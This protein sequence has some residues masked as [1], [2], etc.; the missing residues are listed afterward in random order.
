MKQGFYTKSIGDL[1]RRLSSAI[2]REE[3]KSLHRRVAFR[4]FAVTARQAALFS[5]AF[6]AGWRYPEL[7]VR[8]PVALVLGF[9]VF[10]F[11]VLLHEV[12]HRAVFAKDRPALTRLLGL[13]YALPSGISAT[14][15]TRWHLDHHAELGS[16][17]DDPKRAH[18]SPK[19]NARWFK[20]LYATPAL[21][22]IYFRAARK[23]TAT[24]PADIQKVIARERLA[25]IAFHLAIASSIG[26]LGG[27]ERLLWLYVIPVFLVFPPAFTLNRLGQ[28]YDVVSEEPAKWSTRLV[29]SRL[30][31]FIYLNSN[32]H[33]EHH[34]FP[35][36]PFYRL[37]A[38]ARALAGFY[39]KEG[40]SPRTYRGL[41]F[42]WF[43]RNRKPHTDW[44]LA[45][46]GAPPP[47]RKT[48]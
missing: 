1:K 48:G 32:Y 2:P 30:W 5:L 14:Q 47:A 33:L 25:A 39:E 44:R 8:I 35:G 31:G 38:L 34:Y 4:H 43:V 20:L 36:V 46:A 27:L 6:W 23:E 28:H 21:F 37:P 45:P 22:P 11:T 9:I 16:F 19:R 40:I 29:P 24:Y 13:A 17:T 26:F 18:L 15:F 12:V 42:D 10:D 41:L 3:L 7:W